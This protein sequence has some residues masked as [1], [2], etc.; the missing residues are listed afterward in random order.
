ME[1]RL[2]EAFEQEA[3]Q[4]H[5]P[6]G[7]PETAI[8]RGRRRRAS[9]LIG[10]AALVL[11]LVG[12]TAAG[13]QLL[14]NTDDPEEGNL[15]SA[16]ESDQ[17]VDETIST[18]RTPTVGVVEF[19]WEKVTLPKPTSPTDVWNIQ[20]AATDDGFVAV[21]TGYD[22]T[23]PGPGES[24]LVWQSSDGTDWTPEGVTSPFDGQ[25]DALFTTDDGFVAVV[26]SYD[27][28]TPVASTSIYRSTDGINWTG[29]TV[30][31]SIG[32]N[33][34][35]WFTGA[36]SGNGATVIAGSL[37]TEPDQPPIVF[38]EEGILLEEGY[39]GFT[40]T[41]IATGDTITV[42]GT[43]E[44]YGAG[45]TIRG[46]D[47][48][49]VLSLSE[50]VIEAALQDNF[51]GAV[52]IEQDGIGVE[53]DYN[54]GSYVAT[55]IATG[56][57]ITEGP[58]DELYGIP[59][60]VIVDPET[61]ETILDIDADTFYRAQDDAWKDY[62]DDYRPETELVVLV[63]TGGSVWN[64]VEL[65]TA[66]A[67][68][69]GI[70][71]IGFGQ[72]GFLLSVFSYGPDGAGQDFWRSVDGQDWE[73]FSST[74]E[75]GGSPIVSADGAYYRLS[76]GGRAGIARSAD[77]VTWAP[78]HE[79]ASGGTYYNTLSTGELGLVAVGQEQDEVYG[80]PVIIAKDGRTLVLDGETGR[81]TVTEDAT[82]EILTTIELDVYSVEAP[83]Q[84]IEDEEN[85]TIAITDV[86]G[87]IVME[88]TEEEANAAS[89]ESDREYEYSEPEAAIVF[90]YDGE[91]WFT[92]TTVGVEFAWVQSVAVGSD[93]IVIIGQPSYG[94]PD[95]I[96]RPI[97]S[98]SDG[99]TEATLVYPTEPY[100]EGPETYVWVGRPR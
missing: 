32:V 35:M 74:D 20:V 72:N 89:E 11:T 60:I 44:V 70:G 18:D 41:D 59:Q 69:A 17:A 63:T 28:T 53:I 73:L 86:D 47:G 25:L 57:V 42:V 78:V 95:S 75:P 51:E 23:A 64:R 8:R 27:E 83:A 80:P 98:G 48:G 36:A 56:A 5:A 91:E 24:L 99:T 62:S 45:P 9:N 14:G 10:G 96:D 100:G 58:I 1:D 66:V 46:P 4:L 94:Q 19:A 3:E 30:D 22:P 87:N 31:L 90:S 55:D 71:G 88:F 76:Y 67:E 85:G 12:G 54:D 16:I 68:E 82:G 77:G 93:S 33:Q 79:S 84:I 50:E 43:E 34:Y 13:V 38:E 37:Q 7:S 81:I 49:F 29:G 6:H 2:R 61:G 21:G 39:E 65:A 26:R 40:V 15:A 52:S 92:A 97:E